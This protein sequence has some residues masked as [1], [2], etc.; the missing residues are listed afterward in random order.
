VLARVNN[1]VREA[2][3]FGCPECATP[4][5]D[6]GKEG[7]VYLVRN[8]VEHLLQIGI[9]GN[10]RERLLSHK[11]N[12]FSQID[13]LGPMSGFVA[14]ELERDIKLM[15]KEQLTNRRPALVSGSKFDGHTESWYASEL[16]VAT[17]S[18]LQDMLPVYA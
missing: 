2:E 10:P 3:S 7:W 18:E 5:Y 6:P 1:R 16:S 17:I 4:G 9:T 8:D 13:I 15:L 11:K 14:Q 12:G